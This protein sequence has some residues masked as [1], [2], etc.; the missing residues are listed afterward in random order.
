MPA[1]EL[2]AGVH[3][4]VPE[5]VV[6]DRQFEFLGG[7]A[8]DNRSTPTLEPSEVPTDEIGAAQE[9]LL[10][11]LEEYFEPLVP[12]SVK[13]AVGAVIGLFGE[14]VSALAKSWLDPIAFDDYL[15]KLG[16][17]DPGREDGVDR[18][19]KWMGNKTLLQALATLTIRIAV[20]SGSKV[21]AESLTGES[22]MVR[23]APVNELQTLFVKADGWQGSSCRVHMRPATLLLDMEPQQQRDI[24]MRTAESLLKVL[25]NQPLLSG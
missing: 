7:I 5:V 16:W 21:S 23:V 25:Y 11:S 2:V 12:S 15:E 1:A 22:L 8:V 19:V 4:V 24:L 18:R 13:P 14:R 10:H 20:L 9:Q 3:G 6:N 17:Q